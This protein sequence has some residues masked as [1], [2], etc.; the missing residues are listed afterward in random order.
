MSGRMGADRGLYLI[1]AARAAG[2]TLFQFSQKVAFGIR[3][4]VAVVSRIS[5]FIED[6]PFHR[7]RGTYPNRQWRWGN[8]LDWHGAQPSCQH[9]LRR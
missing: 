5:S 2:Y 3:D 9:T 6:E 7:D 8:S 1:V 4:E